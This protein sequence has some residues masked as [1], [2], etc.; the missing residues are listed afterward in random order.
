MGV[1]DLALDADG[2]PVAV[3]RLALHGSIA[4]HAPGPPAG[5]PRGRRAGRP[6]PPRHRPPARRGR[7]RRR[8]RAGHALPRRRHAGRP[9][10]RPRAAEPRRWS[11]TWPATCSSA[12]AA[13]HRAGIVHRDIKPAN[14]L[15]DESGHAYLTDFGVATMRDA[16]SGLTA[17]ELVVGTPEFMAPEQARGERATPASDV[18]SLG[19]T[20]RYAA[21]GTPPY[22]RG[23]RPGHPQPGRRGQGRPPA[24][25][26]APRRCATGSPRCS[27][28]DP[29][30]DPTAAA[31][32]QGA[33][34]RH[35]VLRRPGRRRDRGPPGRGRRPRRSPAVA[36]RRARSSLVAARRRGRHRRRGGA[37]PPAPTGR[38]RPPTATDREPV[39]HRVHAARLPGRAAQPV[40]PFTDGARAAPTTTPTTTATPPTA[41]RR[42]PTPSTARRSTKSLTANLVP[43]DDIDRYPFHVND[44]SSCSATARSSVTLTAP[45]G[46]VDAARRGRRRHARSAPRVSRDGTPATVDLPDPS[47]LGDDTADLQARVSWVGDARTR[48]PLPPRARPAR[49]DP[50]CH[51]ATRSLPAVGRLDGSRVRVRP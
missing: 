46:V 36:G 45:A 7:R 50:R 12:L 44:A 17:T 15:F 43:T 51:L 18:F 35:P 8:H 20:L 34:R 40:A 19:A 49:T 6:R 41:A 29:S 33:R 4:R 28:S 13:A 37:Q 24:A 25:R 22:G 3:K 2:R 14:V 9:G 11:T 30:A 16:T 1:V 10:A 31:A 23:R 42:R 38:R 21:T 39:D 27:T 48:H 32:A 47:C 26:A 5:P